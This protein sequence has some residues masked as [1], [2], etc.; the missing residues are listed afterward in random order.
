MNEERLLKSANYV[1]TELPVRLAHRIR[2]MQN[3][4]YVVVTEDHIAQVYQLYWEAFEKLRNYPQIN[5]RKDNDQWCDFLRNILNEHASVIPTLSLGL[6]ISSPH[7]SSD[8]LDSF[9]R[10][11]L[12]S[13]ISRRVLAEHHLEL[14][15]GLEEKEG[16]K[17]FVDNVGIIFTGLNVKRSLDKYIK[18][19]LSSV[20]E[21]DRLRSDSKLQEHYK[22]PDIVVDGQVDATF[23]YIRE[24]LE[25]ILLELLLNAVRATA[26]QLHDKPDLIPG[27]IRATISSDDDEVYVRISDQGGGLMLLASQIPS[28]LYSFSHHRNTT[29]LD[30]ERIGALQHLSQRKGGLW[31]T[32]HERLL[33]RKQQSAAEE[34]TEQEDVPQRIGMGLPLSNIYATYFGGS[35]D[36]VS[37]DGW[38]TD[39]YLRLPRLGTNLEDI[40]V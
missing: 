14:T 25:Y 7:L 13:R 40:E 9:L 12:A 29:R 24:H 6:S 11:M 31:G 36:L 5:D 3:L 26:I 37:M 39:V 18:V 17:N 1:R 19:A 38:G 2:D 10:R 22:L 21:S 27:T 28:D 20:H 4:P 23:S 8:E 16:S 33:P 30:I 32:V 15:R 35:L 34:A